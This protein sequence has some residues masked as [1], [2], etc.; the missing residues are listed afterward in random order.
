VN[1]NN[2]SFE[3]TILPHLD[4]AYNLARWLAGNEHDAED[5]VQEAFL[6]AVKF[7]GS[8]R[9]GNP[10][11]WLLTIVRN[12][13]YT[14][15]KRRRE[16][17]AQVHLDESDLELE[18]HSADPAAALAAMS[19][20]EK[21]REAIAQLPLE[22]REVIVLREMEDYSYKE[23]ADLVDLPVGTVMSRLA[24]GRRQLQK[25]ICAETQTSGG[26]L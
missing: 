20:I 16:N 22:F 10:R 13:S 12:T 8:F 4:A 3:Q 14:A 18:D 17:H 25:I 21:V 19:N 6:R 11:A 9:G 15:L 24:R 7:Y 2:A 26:R 23:I 5:I 1:D